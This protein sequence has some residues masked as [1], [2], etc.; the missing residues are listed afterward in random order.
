MKVYNLINNNRNSNQYY[1]I[2]SKFTD[3]VINEVL[4]KEKTIVEEFEL[5]LKKSKNN[6][7]QKRQGNEIILEI[8]TLGVLLDTYTHISETIKPTYKKMLQLVSKKRYK[9]KKTKKYINWAKGIILTLALRNM[10]N[11]EKNNQS[12]ELNNL[13]Q[14]YECL[15]AFGDFEQESKRIKD[16]FTYLNDLDKE[17]SQ[18]YLMKIIKIAKWFEQE[19]ERNL[20]IYTEGVNQFINVKNEKYHWREDR[21]FAMRKPVE[22][23]LNMVGA[24]LLNRHYREDYQKKEVKQLLLP[25]CMRLHNDRCCKARQDII[26]KKC[27]KCTNECTV[28]KLCE[29]VSEKGIDTYIIGHESEVSK[30]NMQSGIVGVS[31]ISRLIEGGW[32]AKELGLSPQC[33]ILDYCGCKHWKGKDVKTNVNVDELISRI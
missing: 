12:I 3:I 4:D 17:K 1:G 2:I 10:D 11:K 28:S 22:Y 21:I 30:S 14:L 32:K 6:Q 24:E 23:H 27:V 20:G 15:D 26:G 9:A 5:H 19:S 29:I 8:L 18:E 7:Y 25:S 33:V 13:K 31:C 16:W